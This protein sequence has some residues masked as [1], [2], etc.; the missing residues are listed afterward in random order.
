MIFWASS[1][2]FLLSTCWQLACNFQ[3]SLFFR[4]AGCCCTCCLGNC[5][6]RYILFVFRVYNL[7]YTAGGANRFI[8][9]VNIQGVQFAPMLSIKATGCFDAENRV[10]NLHHRCRLRRQIAFSHEERVYKLHSLVGRTA[11]LQYLQIYRVY[12]SHFL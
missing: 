5:L 10:Y 2:P 3:G 8:I 4:F 7:H 11:Y 12:K 9:L 6:L 1:Y